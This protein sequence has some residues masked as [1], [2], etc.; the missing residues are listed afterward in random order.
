[1][2]ICDFC[3]EEEAVKKRINPNGFKED[4]KEIWNICWECDKY[5]DWAI[6]KMISKMYGSEVE[7][8]DQWLFKR[9]Q[10]WPKGK[11]FTAT[12]SKKEK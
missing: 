1:M 3:D 11:S 5:I 10:V 8:F 9:E 7:P 12:I 4:K 6:L 2:A